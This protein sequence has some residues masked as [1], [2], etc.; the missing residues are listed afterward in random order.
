MEG[1]E[2]GARWRDHHQHV[3][4]DDLTANPDHTGKLSDGE[5]GEHVLDGFV[6]EAQSTAGP[7]QENID[8]T[9]STSRRSAMMTMR[10]STRN[11]RQ[12][13]SI[14]HDLNGHVDEDENRAGAHGVSWL[15][16]ANARN[17]MAVA[18]NKGLALTEKDLA[19]H[20]LDDDLDERRIN[21]MRDGGHLHTST[22]ERISTTII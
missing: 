2:E 12:E 17:F 9:L 6:D 3:V 16:R 22:S 19:G 13:N 5:S 18:L 7:L 14:E 1:S 20:D 10:L 4:G 21:K 8:G 11:L 15:K